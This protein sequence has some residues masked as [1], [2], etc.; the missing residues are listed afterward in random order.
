MAAIGDDLLPS[1]CCS[2]VLPSLHN[3]V[4]CLCL[5]NHQPSYWWIRL[6]V[7][8]F[9]PI[10]DQRQSLNRWNRYVLGEKYISEVSKK[11]P[12]S[13]AWVS[14]ARLVINITWTLTLTERR[15]VR[16]IRLT[17]WSRY[18]K[19]KRDISSP[20]SSQSIDLRW[21]LSQILSKKRSSP[22]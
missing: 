13:K 6:P 7:A 1:R 12:K 21:R 17:C 20:T 9:K 16:I 22:V 2:F 18:M 14:Q 4:D 3:K 8:E 19:V 15:N 10:R 5:W 11:Y